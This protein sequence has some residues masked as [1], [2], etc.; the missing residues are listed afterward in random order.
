MFRFPPKMYIYIYIVEAL[1]PMPPT[2]RLSWWALGG[3]L[4]TPCG[5][6]G[7]LLGTLG[8]VLEGSWWAFGG[9]L[10]G[11]WGGLGGS[12]GGLAAKKPKDSKKVPNRYR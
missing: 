8:E 5:A 10:G 7:G 6:V 9:V 2:R 3:L 4:G 12:L 11:S 1:R